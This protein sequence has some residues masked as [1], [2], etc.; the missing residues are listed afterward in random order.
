MKYSFNKLVD[1]NKLQVLT[2]E[3]YRA[4]S[5]PSAIIGMDGDVLTGSGWQRICTDFHRQHPLTLK[6]CVKSNTTRK[7]ALDNGE[8]FVINRCPHGLIEA[9]SPV[10]I[11]GKHIANVFAGQVFLTAPDKE[12]EKFFMEQAQQFGFDEIEYIKAFREVPIFTEEKFRG[13]LSFLAKFAQMIAQMG[14]TRLGELESIRAVKESENRFNILFNES[15]DP[16]LLYKEGRFIDGNQAAVD[17]LGMES[18]DQILN[19]CPADISPEFQPD[20]RRSDEK[21]VAMDEL[22]FAHGNHK[23]EWMHKRVDGQNFSVEVML[24][25]IER[26][27]FHFFLVV[28]RDITERI[29]AQKEL[30]KVSLDLK[31]RVKK[32]NCLYSISKIAETK[33]ITIDNLMQSVID[34]IP[35]SLQYPEITCAR[36]WVGETSFKTIYFKETQWKLS[37]PICIDAKKVGCLEIFH[38]KIPK[39]GKDPFLKEEQDFIKGICERMGKLIDRIQISRK[40]K[41]IEARYQILTD[42]FADGIAIIQ[43]DQYEF[44]N[45]AFATMAGYTAPKFLIG[46]QYQSFISTDFLSQYSDSVI[47][48]TYPHDVPDKIEYKFLPKK[49][50]AIWVEEKRNVI[51]WNFAPALLCTLRDITKKK[52]RE[53]S[54]TEETK[55]LRQENV[56]LRSSLKERYRFQN[57]IGMSSGMQ[58]VYDQILTAANSNANISI[59]GESGTGKE[60]VAQAIHDLSNR[61]FLIPC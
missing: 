34:I 19:S 6:A 56:L 49:G 37:S 18:L 38:K 16:A 10:I 17:M 43:N 44:V 61:I 32:L 27:K 36:A 40:L 3:L 4:T 47:L 14:H 31:D 54:I 60:L 41:E 20:G 26:K 57:I 58:R 7:G 2:D 15:G 8:P 46:K 50:Q 22:A 59:F 12:K 21:L 39:S 35:P 25:S 29:K 48:G 9:S 53:T 45:T 11:S 33:N 52:E 28:W 13:I 51:N 24:T 30:E 23:F 1:I 55:Q 42:Q 5:I